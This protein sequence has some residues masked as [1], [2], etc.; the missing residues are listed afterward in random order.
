MTATPPDVNDDSQDELPS[1]ILRALRE[2]ER[3]IT[4]IT[5][6]VDRAILDLA[7]EHFKGR[8]AGL[9][10]IANSPWW[11]AAAAS[12]V[13][14]LVLFTAQKPEPVRAESVY[15]DADGSGKID[16]ADVLYLARKNDNRRPSQAQ[17]DA[18]AFR[19]VAL[20][21]RVDAS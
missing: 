15:A 5:P 16:I 7:G 21:Q 11:L 20:S 12:V 8:E 3:G 13:V 10:K 4:T 1:N 18:F 19:L 9:R 2:S 14:A 17:L 6:Q